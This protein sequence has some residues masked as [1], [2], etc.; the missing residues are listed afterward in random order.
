MSGKPGDIAKNCQATPS[1][2]QNSLLTEAAK[3]SVVQAHTVIE[4]NGP[5]IGLRWT[6]ASACT[7]HMTNNKT[8]SRRLKISQDRFRVES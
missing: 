7:C 2:K 3:M 6:L 5:R 8:F 4:G 1:P